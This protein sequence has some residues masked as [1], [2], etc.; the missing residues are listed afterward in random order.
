MGLSAADAQRMAQSLGLE[1]EVLG[2]EET[3]DARP[4][5][6]LEQ[7]PGPGQRV[8]TESVVSVILAAGRALEMPDVVGYDLESVLEGL[9]SEGLLVVVDEVR[10]TQSRGTIL[11]QEP[12]AAVEIRAGDTVTLTV[13]GGSNVPIALNVNLN[14]QVVL[15]QAW[16]TQFGFTP[17][18]SVPVT[19]RWRCTQPFGNSYKVFVHIL[20]PDL[21]TLVAQRDVEPVNGLRPTS[22]WTPGEVINDPH[23]VVLPEN[24][25]PGTYQIR[26]GLYDD[27]GRLPVVDP[28]G[29]Q[30]VDDTVFVTQIEVRP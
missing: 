28:G 18:D 26:V 3:S 4:G 10:D 20:T 19:L 29:A 9:E 23:Q 16:V 2:E 27:A 8:P 13:S 14:D 17:G 24:T 22:S 11:E 12:S 6:V 30:V 7:T 1:I 15:E 21:S 5:A 25:A